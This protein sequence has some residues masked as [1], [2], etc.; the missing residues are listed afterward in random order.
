MKANQTTVFRAAVIA[1]LALFPTTVTEA[2]DAFW[3]TNYEAAIR[4]AD[5]E[6]KDLLLNFTGS[7]W[8]VWC[9]RL[10]REVFSRNGYRRAAGKQF[11][12][13]KLDFPRNLG[14]IKQETRLQNESLRKIFDPK[15][16]PTIVLADAQG[17][18][19]A[20][21]GYKAGGPEVYLKH[22]DELQGIRQQRDLL[23]HEAGRLAGIRKARKLGEALATVGERLS[24][25][26]YQSTRSEIKSLDPRDQSG[27]RNQ[28]RKVEESGDESARIRRIM[29]ESRMRAGD[30]KEILTRIDREL[31]TGFQDPRNRAMAMFAKA[32]L[33][34]QNGRGK[35]ARAIT[36]TLSDQPESFQGTMRD[37]MLRLHAW[38]MCATGDV[39]AGFGLLQQVA[40]Q[41]ANP[42]WKS[43]NLGRMA[44]IK[45][46]F[47][48]REGAIS[49]FEQAIQVAPNNRIK[50]AYREELSRLTDAR[51]KA[52]RLINRRGQREAPVISGA[53]LGNPTPDETLTQYLERARKQ[54]ETLDK[55]GDGV[56]SLEEQG[57]DQRK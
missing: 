26:H 37:Q 32:R 4:K 51:A 7:D 56:L 40:D 10:D 9:V 53:P 33:L 13:V 18:P 38:A 42:H 8:C 28:F 23:F 57:T 24:S 16:Y 54:F 36:E 12:H 22:L 29:T 3:T 30:E 47:G 11:V 21:T 55:N 17:R 52:P 27:W 5:H 1:L 35:E 19:Y 20:E 41:Q 31:E 15:G 46:D 2:A 34:L 6:K 25:K 43:M 39:E 45:A 49:A 48:D 50:A 14:L 44:K